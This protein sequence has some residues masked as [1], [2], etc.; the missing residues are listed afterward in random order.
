MVHRRPYDPSKLNEHVSIPCIVVTT[1]DVA[2]VLKLLLGYMY[3][4]CG[5]KQVQEIELCGCTGKCEDHDVVKL[6]SFR[7]ILLKENADVSLI[8][9]IL[10]PA[11]NIEVNAAPRACLSCMLR[12]GSL[13]AG[14]LG[15]LSLRLSVHNYKY[16]E[17]LCLLLGQEGCVRNCIPSSFE[18]VGH[19]AHFNLT[20]EDEPCKNIIG[21]LLLDTHPTVSLVVNKLDSIDTKYREFKME[22]LAM[23]R[24]V[25]F[26]LNVERLALKEG[27]TKKLKREHENI[28]EEKIT[29]DTQNLLSEGVEKSI[30]Y[31][32]DTPLP[33][34]I[35]I[36]S[37]KQN[38][39]IFRFPYN[40]VYWNTR[41]DTEHRRMINSIKQEDTVID[42]FAGV[43]PFSL[44]LAR[45]RFQNIL[46]EK[47]KKF[48]TEHPKIKL[49]GCVHANDLNPHCY[50][51][52]IQNAKENRI[53]IASEGGV[54]DNNVDNSSSNSNGR[55]MQSM[56]GKRYFRCTRLLMI[57]FLSPI[58]RVQSL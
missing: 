50:S 17:A 40:K 31:P 11:L 25:L 19:I 23:R 2:P 21:G 45:Q 32:A 44:P 14:M 26:S 18:Q 35:F 6:T 54:E 9:S 24:N 8:R 30:I 16:K 15:T 53:R 27:T 57:F 33:S 22:V 38:Q 56:L 20:P 12:T 5:I 41:L 39:C 3:K 34:D 29:R 55:K 48:V 10:T 1:V 37:I 46:S 47:K 7:A 13:K 52:L 36:V 49:L 4:K 43:G 58:E 28:H 42:F 51:A